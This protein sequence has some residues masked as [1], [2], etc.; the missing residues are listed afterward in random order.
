[1]TWLKNLYRRFQ[2][3]LINR[4]LAKAIE[5]SFAGTGV[6]NTIGG[7]A[8]GLD[9]RVNHTDSIQIVQDETQR[10]YAQGM[11]YLKESV[12]EQT[13]DGTSLHE[14]LSRY[15]G[16]EGFYLNPD[17]L[18]LAR[19]ENDSEKMLRETRTSIVAGYGADIKSEE[20][21]KKMID[22]RIQIMYNLQKDK[23]K[24]DLLKQIR[25]AKNDNDDKLVSQ[26]EREFYEK[27][28]R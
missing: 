26:L 15:Q 27:Y 3:W 18:S 6:S 11:A 21:K 23:L 5:D 7:G 17:L 1:M 2:M 25:A 28:A 4:R 10:K 24:R 8:L 16:K 19:R 12:L 20:D 9:Q 13:K 14:V 22:K